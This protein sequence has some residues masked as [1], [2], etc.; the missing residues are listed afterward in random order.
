MKLLTALFIA[1]CV[2]VSNVYGL[3]QETRSYAIT[4]YN[5]TREQYVLIVGLIDDIKEARVE[6]GTAEKKLKEW[7]KRYR[8]RTESLPDELE[9]MR[10]LMYDMIDAAKEIVHDYQ[11]NNQT[12]KDRLYAFEEIKNEL[13]NEM[14]AV[15]YLLQ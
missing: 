10:G 13:F 12:T 11:P 7:D 4:I 6:A 1:G 15:R 14:T 3:D 2:L 8:D 9:K 5:F